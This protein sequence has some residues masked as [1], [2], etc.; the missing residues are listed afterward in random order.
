MLSSPPPTRRRL[1]MRAAPELIEVI[2]HF[3]SFEVVM[4]LEH[5]RPADVLG[6]VKAGVFPEVVVRHEED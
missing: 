5:G 1:E 3:A 6:N 2:E 4:K